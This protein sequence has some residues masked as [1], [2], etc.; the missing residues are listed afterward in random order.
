MK[1]WKL[2]ISA[3]IISVFMIW[4]CVAI[5]GTVQAQEQVAETHTGY[6]SG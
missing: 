5:D 2:M 4:A 6:Y 3:V 1:L